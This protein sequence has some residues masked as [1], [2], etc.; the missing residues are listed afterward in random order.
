MSFE[1][2]AAEIAQTLEKKQ[3]AYGDSFGK[4]S[5]IM[6][7]LLKENYI[8]SQDAF[9]IPSALLSEL[10]T[11]VRILD[12]ISRIATSPTGDKMDESPYA[13]IAGYAILSLSRSREQTSS[14]NEETALPV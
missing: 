7:I 13:D 2:T 4:T 14:K 6:R 11:I 3:E 8:E 10:L 9:L 12:K 1:K 5:D